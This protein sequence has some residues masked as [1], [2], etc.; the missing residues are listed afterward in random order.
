MN[1]GRE[2]GFKLTAKVHNE[3]ALKVLLLSGQFIG[4]LPVHV[5]KPFVDRA[6]LAPL[7][8]EKT[9]YQTQLGAIV[10][11]HPEVGRK[12]KEFLTCLLESH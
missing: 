1:A 10:R 2:L 7:A 11:K 12:T 9:S 5:A 4:F 6:E 3:E 8:Q